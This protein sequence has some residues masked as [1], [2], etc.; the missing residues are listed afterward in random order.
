MKYTNVSN[1]CKI[2]DKNLFFPDIEMF[3]HI[4]RMSC[5]FE[6]ETWSDETKTETCKLLICSVSGMRCQVPNR[7]INK[8]FKNSCKKKNK[9]GEVD[10]FA[11]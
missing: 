7:I 5:C 1:K 10:D 6:V 9:I 4:P 11:N 2:K 8:G 3:K